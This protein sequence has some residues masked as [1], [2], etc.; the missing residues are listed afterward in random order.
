MNRYR[1]T[2]ERIFACQRRVSQDGKTDKEG[3]K[4]NDQNK[5]GWPS[6]HRRG[7]GKKNTDEEIKAIRPSAAS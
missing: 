5:S 2:K 1:N 6:R 7:A 3:K 4:K